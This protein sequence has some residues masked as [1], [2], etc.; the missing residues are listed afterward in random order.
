MFSDMSVTPQF[1]EYV[2][3]LD[4]VAQQQ[5]MNKLKV[6]ECKQ[7]DLVPDPYA[8]TKDLWSSDPSDWPDVQFGDI[9]NYLIFKTGNSIVCYDVPA[10]CYV[11]CQRGEDAFCT[12]LCFACAVLKFIKDR[13]QLSGYP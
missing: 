1:S 4:R 6:C 2:R 9:Y 12:A 3:Q 10:Y 5:Y 13:K 11:N 7:L 8:V